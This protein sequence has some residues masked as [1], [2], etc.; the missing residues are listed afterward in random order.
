MIYFFPTT[1]IVVSIGAAFVYALA[2][3]YRHATYW[4]AAAVLTATV[5]L[6]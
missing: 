1:Q 5:T 4:L 6:L 2:G 3:D